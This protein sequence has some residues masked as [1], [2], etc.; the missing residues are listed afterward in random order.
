MS[1]LEKSKLPSP[2]H[3]GFKPKHPTQTALQIITDKIY[4]NIDN[5]RI[6][7]STLCGLSRVFDTLNNTIHHRKVRRISIDSFWFG[8]YL[9]IRTLSARIS[10]TISRQAVPY[11]VPQSS[12]LGPLLFNIHVSDM[13]RHINNCLLVQYADDSFSIATPPTT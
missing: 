6:S 3:H 5:K 8:N 7:L 13:S 10:N 2:T 4:N 11:G 1:F 9:N 12:I